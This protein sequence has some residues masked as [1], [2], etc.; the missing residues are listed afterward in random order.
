MVMNIEQIFRE[1]TSGSRSGAVRAT[2]V[3]DYLESP[4]TFWCSLHAPANAKDPMTDHQQH[5][6]NVGKTH[7]TQVYE[8]L[9]PGGVQ[10]FH[11]D[12]RI[13]FRRALEV[14][15][16][17]GEFLKDM[18][19]VC[20]SEGLTGR[21]DVL[22]R[23]DGVPS[24]F[25][26]FSYR[27]VEIKSSRKLRESQLLQGA[28]YNRVLGMVQGYE[29][30][31]FQM[32]N[33]DFDVI[34]VEMSEVDE[35][36][37]Q[38]LAEVREVMGGRPVEPCHGAARWPWV[39][40]VD[41]LAVAANDVSLITGV[42]AATRVNLVQAGFS[43]VDNI[44]VADEADLVSVHRIGSA[45]A[46]KMMVSAQAI[47]GKKPLRREELAELR[48][49]KTEVFFDFEGAQDQDED[50]GLEMVNY[51][52]GAA[53]RTAGG[54][55]QYK[56]F[57]ADSFDE[58]DDNLND[59]LRWA[60]SLDDP[61]FYHWH[62][63]ERNHLRK[64]VERYGVDSQLAGVVL[65]RL[66]D[67][68]PWATKGYAFPAFGESLKAIAKSLGFEWRQADVTGVGSMTLYM[69]Y[70]ESGSMDQTAKNKIIVYNEDDCFATM[71]I[72]D[73]VIAQEE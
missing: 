41:G 13:G 36:L 20:W 3:A 59:F 60:N 57:F 53:Y 44:A 12:E 65:D 62:H 50:N 42:G 70:V 73:W 35:R 37:D 6:F 69:N 55:A 17:G 64:M 5:I 47:Q 11:I 22:E 56:A 15:F 29:P 58:E 72:Y 40:Y 63:Y 9:Y 33:R 19:L 8:Q 32:V 26:D 30:P 2:W 67:L 38:V 34:P 25:G 61:V 14:M 1:F 45:K 23:V 10:E 27:V 46:K 39:S 24:V 16:E 21:P 54:K 28:L 4:V 18:P 48:R 71:H 52:I 7:Q 31:V 66:E 49:G 51:L 43:T 68:S